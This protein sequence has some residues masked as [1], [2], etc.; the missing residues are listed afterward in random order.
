MAN[1]D[2]SKNWTIL[3]DIPV[4]E[5]AA[6]LALY[7]SLLRGKAGLAQEQPQITEAAVVSQNPEPCIIIKAA[8]GN[9]GQNGFSWQFGKNRI[10]ISGD[11]PRGLWNGIFDFLA[12]LDIK[13]PTPDQEELPQTG[14]GANNTEFNLKTDKALF[15]SISSAQDRRRLFI[16]E[17]TGVKEREKLVIWAA[18]NKYDALVFSLKEKSLWAKA[19]AKAKLYPASKNRPGNCSTVP[20]RE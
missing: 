6:E 1:L 15:Y 18:R 13:W 5:A 8:A 19:R 3:A 20:C 9:Q 4:R 16:D 2:V 10:E 14:F 7:I 12:A 17:K 11:S